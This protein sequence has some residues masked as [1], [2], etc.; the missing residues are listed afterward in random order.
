MLIKVRVNITA[1]ANKTG[2]QSVFNVVVGED[3]ILK[4]FTLLPPSGIIADGGEIAIPF[5]ALDQKGDKITNFVTLAKQTTLNELTFSTS[6]GTLVLSENDDGT[7]QLTFKDDTDAPGWG[8]S[9]STDGLDRIASLTSIVV[10]GRP[11]NLTI[12]IQDKPRP[13]AIKD[14]A[15]DNVLVERGS[16]IR[17]NNINDGDDKSS[18][19][20]IDQYGKE[21]DNDQAAAFFKASLNGQLEGTDFKDYKFAVQATLKGDIDDFNF[22][23]VNVKRL[24]KKDEAGNEIPTNVF[25]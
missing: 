5:E 6:T 16:T 4:S 21:M 13:D 10:G 12:Y 22:E 7:A 9:Q 14:V 19:L 2:N 17:F 1:I 18:I 8:N 15:M 20:F 24:N 3:Q 23:G 25:P 11:S